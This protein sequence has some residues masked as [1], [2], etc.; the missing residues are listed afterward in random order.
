VNKPIENAILYIAKQFNKELNLEQIAT[1]AGL[2]KFHFHR[3]FQKEMGETVL[4]YIHRLRMEHALH[5][6]AMYTTIQFMEVAFQC[7]Y[8]S[9]AEFSRVFKKQFKLSPTA[10]RKTLRV[11]PIYTPFVKNEIRLPIVYQKKR[12]LIVSASN[13]VKENLDALFEKTIELPNYHPEYFGVFMDVPIHVKPEKCRYYG[14]FEGASSGHYSELI[15]ELE[16]GYYTYLT[17]SGDLDA[18]IRSIVAFK[19]QQIDH[20]PYE[21]AS[22]I[23]FEKINL[24]RSNQQFDYFSVERKLFIRIRKKQQDSP[25]LRT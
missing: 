8:S 19:E 18:L 10:Y 23:A 7:G 3:L 1:E 20:S 5:L 2:S 15:V 13:L 21:I 25:S 9:P 12:S 4:N 11:K 6:L 24:P 14:G 22:F 16:E 17:V